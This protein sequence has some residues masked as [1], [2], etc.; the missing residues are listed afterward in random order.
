M[1]ENTFTFPP[2]MKQLGKLLE[3]AGIQ[4]AY[5]P[6]PTPVPEVLSEEASRAWPNLPQLPLPATNP[7][8]LAAMR[9]LTA[10]GDSAV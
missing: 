6:N 4:L 8:Q 5:G 1:S 2:A 10:I 9:Q 7:K 3:E